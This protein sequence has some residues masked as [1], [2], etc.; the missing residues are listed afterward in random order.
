VPEHPEGSPESPKQLT[1]A[2]K[3]R[4]GVLCCVGVTGRLRGVRCVGEAPYTRVFQAGSQLSARGHTLH[5]P[6]IGPGGVV[7]A[8]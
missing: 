2:T 7:R 1:D 8:Q 4:D 3:R 5:P 6:L